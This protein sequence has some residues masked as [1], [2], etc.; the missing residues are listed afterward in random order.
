M[1]ITA[2]GSMPGTDF[3]E[4]SRM[5]ADLLPDLLAWPELPARDASS[6]M[7][8]RTLGL[9]EQA[10][11]LTADGWRLAVS[12]DAAQQ[13]A[14]RWWRHDLDDLE[15]LTEHHEGALKVAITGPWTLASAVRLA[16]PTMN[17]VI[18][19]AGACRDLGQALA[20]G[21]G[22]LTMLLGQRLGRRL[23]VQ[24]DE[25][26]IGAVLGGELATF[27][28]LQRYR[29]PETDEVV[30]SWRWLVDAIGAAGATAWLHSCAPG[31]DL[32]LVGRAGFDGVAL[33]T[34]FIDARGL[35]GIGSWLDAGRSLGL[36]TVR[37]DQVRVPSVDEIVAEA[38]RV[39]RPLEIYAELLDANVVL[40]PACGLASWPAGAAAQLLERLAPAAELVTEQ[41]RR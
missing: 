22:E 13:R 21:I 23:I 20:E 15:E 2:L 8:G 12:S 32:G 4:A 3:R 38:L 39:L 41:L 40:T 16:H 35:D 37:T 31:L 33:D 5:V 1:R 7:I 19:D 30:G 14:A 29:T 36:G 27:S 11:N 18:A 26:A 28:G 10:A 6:A 25:P 9:L 24:V 17:H 34:R